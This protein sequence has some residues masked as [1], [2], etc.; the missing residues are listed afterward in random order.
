[1]PLKDLKPDIGGF[2]LVR[3]ATRCGECNFMR[4]NMQF[5]HP[6]D[7]GILCVH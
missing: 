2:T 6:R 4:L 5:P 1:M 3:A 7:F